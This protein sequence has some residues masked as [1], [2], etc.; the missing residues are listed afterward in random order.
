MAQILSKTQ[1]YGLYIGGKYVQPEGA[2]RLPVSNPAT[3]EEWATIVNARTEDVNEAV[4]VARA[5]FDTG[6]GS[7]VDLALSKSPLPNAAKYEELKKFAVALTP[8]TANSHLSNREGLNGKPVLVVFTV[9][10][11]PK[12]PF[13]DSVYL[14][15]DISGWSATAIRMD[16]VDALH[17]RVAQDYGSGTKFLFR[18]TRG[19]W[20]SAERGQDGL[21][22]APRPFTVGN[23]DVQR[24]DNVVYHWGDEDQSAPGLGN[25]PVPT[26][27][28]PLPFN[29]PPHK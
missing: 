9:Q 22:V 8:Q 20:R 17:Y 10:V 18:Y 19:S 3:G 2:P 4:R 24:I 26:P 15:T 12:T 16:R 29:T 25:G 14:A 11:P 13:N 1:D 23:A 5:A 21:E 6:N 7:L 27:F 28:Q